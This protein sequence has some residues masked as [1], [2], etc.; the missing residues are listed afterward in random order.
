METKKPSNPLL[1]HEAAFLSAGGAL[2]IETDQLPTSGD[3]LAAPE[4]DQLVATSLRVY[5]VAEQLS[6]SINEVLE[7]I[8]QGSLYAIKIPSGYACPVFQFYGEAILPG[9]G[10]VLAA[11]NKRAHP[12][13]IQR[14]FLFPTADLE[15][16]AGYPLS[17]REWLMKGHSPDPVVLLARGL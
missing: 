16:I 4:Y 17:P 5:E 9:I 6:V 7:R 2:G 8:N 12:V 15:L 10:V 13:A 11:I 1:P 3:N 14:F